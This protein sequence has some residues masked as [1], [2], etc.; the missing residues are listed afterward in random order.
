VPPASIRGSSL[1]ILKL[2]CK[3]CSIGASCSQSRAPLLISSRRQGAARC[4]Q[5]A[6][7]HHQT[8]TTNNAARLLPPRGESSATPR[9]KGRKEQALPRTTTP[10][11][12]CAWCRGRSHSLTEGVA[13]AWTW[14]SCSG[15]ARVDGASRRVHRPTSAPRRGEIARPSASTHVGLDTRP[16]ARTGDSRGEI[17]VRDTSGI[18][19][20]GD[21]RPRGERI[22]C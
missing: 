5:D 10:Q 15:R 13:I 20:R 12:R 16:H 3:N 14:R 2:P 1:L 7:V 11:P 21:R 6:P 8:T 17:C 4:C 19:R 9:G 18:A 22:G